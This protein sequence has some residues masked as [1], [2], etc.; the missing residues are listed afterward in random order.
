VAEGQPRRK[1]AGIDFS[2][3]GVGLAA[4]L[5]IMVMPF[6]FSI[7]DGIGFGFVAYVVVRAAEGRSREVHPFMWIASAAFALYFLVPLL[8]DT[9]DWI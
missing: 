6:T 9:F 3:L 5:T 1:L 8:Q 2:D 4:A 7:A